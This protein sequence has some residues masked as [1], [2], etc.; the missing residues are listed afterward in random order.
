MP[1]L[2]QEFLE[3]YLKFGRLF[4]E[5]ISLE[6][7]ARVA[8]LAKKSPFREISDFIFKAGGG[9]VATSL[10]VLV[11]D[12]KVVD[13]AKRGV[14][15]RARERS[16]LLLLLELLRPGLRVVGSLS[17]VHPRC[18]AMSGECQAHLAA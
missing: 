3:I 15:A 11:V 9:D 2:W 6:I 8:R 17:R 7:W 4:R 5:R 18:A 10:E 12:L 14:R 13:G 1:W 16:K